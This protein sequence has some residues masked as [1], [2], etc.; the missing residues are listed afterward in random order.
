MHRAALH[1][2][3]A[4]ARRAPPV[5]GALPHGRQAAA[6]RLVHDPLIKG[7]T[8]KPLRVGLADKLGIA[9]Q[10]GDT[11]GGIA[12]VGIGSRCGHRGGGASR[13]SRRPAAPRASRTSAW[14]R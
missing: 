9:K 10:G 14:T 3:V 1:S 13:A 11:G 4:P 2:N 8:G 12:A 5:P 7:P 6:A